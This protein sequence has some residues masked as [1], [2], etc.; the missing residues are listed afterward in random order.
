MSTER[1]L[2]EGLRIED[3]DAVRVLALDRPDRRNA[4]SHALVDALHDEIVA[5]ERDPAVRAVVLTGA[6]GAFS[7]G[8]D[9]RGP[10][11][12]AGEVVR[13]HYNPLV[14]TMLGVETP[15]VAAV[16]GVA[17]GAA[18]SL[19]LACDLRVAASETTFR[20]A[21][22]KIGLVPDAG[23]TWLLPRIVGSGRAAEMALLGEPVDAD[24]A[25]A[26]G[27]VNRVEAT[28]PQAQQAAVE[29]AAGL[30]EIA[31]V[32]RRLLASAAT[33]DLTTQLDEEAVAQGKAQHGPQFA[34]A[35]AA[36]AGRG[37]GAGR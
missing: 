28:G 30:G 29:L 22:A 37:R 33:N 13:D 1:R 8:A 14:R 4:L 6:E 17:A 26:W 27:L 7:A 32:T 2:D 12:D 9:L 23:A 15:M 34:A 18:V 10:A 19:A 24:T 31:G 21:F 25:L 20:L 35:R 36:F 5:A 16:N 3:R 11:A